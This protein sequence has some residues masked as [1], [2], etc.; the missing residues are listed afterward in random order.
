MTIAV[1]SIA[2]VTDAH[3]EGWCVDVT[4]TGQAGNQGLATYDF[5]T[6]G[7]K[8]TSNF[9]I[10]CYSPG[11]DGGS[12]TSRTR[13]LYGTAVLRQPYPNQASLQ[14]TDSVSDL[15]IRVALSDFA[16]KDDD[17]AGPSADP[18]VFIA[19]GWATIGGDTTA[20]V[21]TDATNAVTFEY[22]A[23]MACWD[24]N[25]GTMMASR[26]K[27]NFV[28]SVHARTAYGIDQVLFT[29]T[30]Q[31]SAV[32]D[33]DNVATLT[34]T[35]RTS[36]GLY[37]ESWQ[38][39][40][41]I[42]QFTQGETLHCDF[43]VIP[44]VGNTAQQVDTTGNT[45]LAAEVFGQNTLVLICDKD[46][47]LDDAVY[48][49]TTG[50]DTTGDGSS[51][52]PYATISKG[53]NNGNIV[54]LQAGTHAAVGATHT[55]LNNSS[56]IVVQ[57]AP[58]LTS[59]DCTVQIDATN[60]SSRTKRLCYR[61]LTV[62]KL[63]TAS[64]LTGDDVN[65]LWYDQC[66]FDRN[67]IGSA[68]AGPA[69]KMV[70]A[71]WTDCTGI[72]PVYWN[73]ISVA[74]RTQANLFDGCVFT[75]PSDLNSRLDTG[76]RYFCNEFNGP[77]NVQHKPAT[78]TAAVV[79][80]N[81]TDFWYAWNNHPDHDDSSSANGNVLLANEEAMSRVVIIG[82]VLERT[83][84]AS[85]NFFLGDETSVVDAL[86]EHMTIA[87]LQCSFCYNSTGSSPV[88]YSRVFTKACSIGDIAVK[89]DTFG[90][91]DGG[92]IG[93]WPVVY[94]AGW[95]DNHRTGFVSA[96]QEYHGL[97]ATEGDPGYTDDQSAEGSGGGNGNYL[98]ADASTLRNRVRSGTALSA[99]D[100][101]GTAYRNNGTDAIGAINTPA[102]THS[103]GPRL[104]RARNLGVAP[105]NVYPL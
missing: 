47:A 93:N 80:R 17:S 66:V 50:N 82:S 31:T 5:G 44:K 14:E 34:K 3:Y 24:I 8:T 73:L 20:A 10:D 12:S 46:D 100:L 30:G 69:D 84:L 98:P 52:N 19:A 11:F 99:Y 56:W 13:T 29:V 25:G 78:H 105:L 23:V 94:G 74:S 51:G 81:S 7:S 79:A 42:A 71:Y 64:F 90:T 37:A 53:I 45:T 92:R 6:P 89:T 88:T 61:G 85:A 57:P 2:F 4:L 33:A 95:A 36:T 1:A 18:R 70:V 39:T 15:V 35:Q 67:G 32:S 26:V 60:R 40:I 75:N 91:A 87:G 62:T 65:T 76:Y 101:L 38:A 49:S 16:Y 96:D 97:Y 59:N 68:S 9:Y 58:G 72:E 77:I 43:K 41:P 86:V 27:D 83:N 55:Q 22:P 63:S 104:G 54:Y 28:L 102:P 21:D 103:G 48:V